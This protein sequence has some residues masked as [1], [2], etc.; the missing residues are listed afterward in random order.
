VFTSYYGNVKKLP[1]DLVPVGISQGVPAWYK[2]RVEKCLAPSWAMLKLSPEEY[3]SQYKAA[4]LSKLDPKAIFELLG[5]NAVMLCWEEPGFRCHRRLVAE[6]LEANLGITITEVG[7]DRPAV[8]AYAT[9]PRKP[10]RGRR[11]SKAK[12][13]DGATGLLGFML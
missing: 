8:P 6:W 11:G 10:K 3:D 2:G 7:F 5:D 1:E 13:K 4:V 9:M 12:S